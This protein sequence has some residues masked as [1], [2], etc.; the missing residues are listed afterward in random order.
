MKFTY[1]KFLFVAFFA[2]FAVMA[3]EM[4]A[5]RLLAP[6]FGTSILVWTNLIGIVL[7]ALAVGFWLGG[8]VAEKPSSKIVLGVVLSASGVLSMTVPWLLKFLFT[9]SSFQ[10][11]VTST[12]QLAGLLLTSGLTFVLP[13]G[14]LG[15]VN[16]ILVKILSDESNHVG[17]SSGGVSAWSTVGSIAGTFAGGLWLIPSIG[18]RNT[19][20]I[21]A[22]GLVLLGCF[23]LLRKLKVV[24]LVLVLGLILSFSFS[25]LGLIKPAMGMIYEGETP[26]HYVQVIQNPDG[27]R[28]MIFNSGFGVQ[29]IYVPGGEEVG[30]GYYD[31]FSKLPYLFTDEQ[32]TSENPLKVLMI[33]LAGGEILHQLDAAF[34]SR[35]KLEAVEIDPGVVELSKEFFDMNKLPV[36][37]HVEDARTFLR[38]SQKQY[39]VIMVDAY[40]NELYL[41]WHLVTEEFWNEVKRRTSQNGIV[42]SNLL[43]GLPSSPLLSAV[44]N[45][46]A[47]VFP[48]VAVGQSGYANYFLIASADDKLSERITAVEELSLAK[49]VEFDSTKLL[50]TD[51]RSPVE[52]LAH[53]ALSEM[54][55]GKK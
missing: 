15:F 50:L 20:L 37:V 35:V 3:L 39:D 22:W 5:S 25:R 48:E 51:D 11:V 9:Q 8:K 13:I 47:K 36:T 1:S 38:D 14:L 33:G 17:K 26:Y 49:G 44:Q 23:F 42:A 16:P 31:R 12:G 6:F 21:I 29:S 34:G 2:G 43:A 7:A 41:P 54:W 45:T 4:V 24:I 19:L 28:G 32:F 55:A 40:Q 46:V 10:G 27:A 18:T 53:K 52:Q 30:Y